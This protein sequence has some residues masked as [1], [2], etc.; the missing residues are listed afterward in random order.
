MKRET[1][2]RLH[3]AVQACREI[4]K[5]TEGVSEEA[6]VGDRGL[7]LAVHKLLE[8]VGESLAFAVRTDATLLERIPDA[9]RAISTR[10]RITHRYDSVDYRLI[11]GITQTRIPALRRD[12]ER[13]M[14]ADPCERS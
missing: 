12:I 13:V 14:D 6:F 11:W 10:N 2:K 9:R 1:R 4:E 8:I 7:H 5:F 3:D